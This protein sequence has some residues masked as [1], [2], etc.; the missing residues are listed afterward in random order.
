MEVKYFGNSSFLLKSKKKV[1]VLT[2]PFDVNVKINIKKI[3]PEIVLASH[4]IKKAGN[5]YYF[6]NTA[7]EYEI[8]DIFV[9]GFDS[10]PESEDC[11]VFLISMDHISFGLIDKNVNQLSDVIVDEMGIVNVLFIS[12]DEEVG[13]KINKLVD[14]ASEIDPQILIPMDFDEK[15]LEQLKKSVGVKEIEKLPK[16]SVKSDEFS[17][18]DIPMRIVVLEKS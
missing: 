18:E 12:L 16:L 15:S 4:K 6:I 9:Y 11:D 1:K 17:G 2:N 8:K 10:K 3:Q 5:D 7:G 13:M 14:L